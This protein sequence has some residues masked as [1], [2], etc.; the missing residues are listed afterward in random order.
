MFD[1]S[2]RQ[3]LM[4]RCFTSFER[5]I[6]VALFDCSMCGQCIV[7]STGLVCPMQCPKQMRNGPCGGSIHG[8]C[9]VHP[10]QPCAWVKAYE[11]A[12]KWGAGMAKKL[13]W[14]QPPVDWRL[15]GTAAWLN[16]A[17]RKTDINGHPL[18]PKKEN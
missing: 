2:K 6:K 15:W 8:K 14:I 17:T 12:P 13:E 11:R 4:T 10:D 9:E 16:V 5:F 7:R 18:P 3:N 1:N